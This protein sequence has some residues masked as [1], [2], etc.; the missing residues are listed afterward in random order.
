VRTLAALAVLA[1]AARVLLGP[2]TVGYDGQWA[3]LWGRDLAEGARPDMGGA[4]APTPHPLVNLVATALAPLGAAGEALLAATTYVAAA[5]LVLGCFA[6]GRALAGP[7]AGVLFAALVATRPLV[8]GAAMGVSVDVPWLALVLWAAALQARDAPRHRATAAL[9]VLAGLIR[10]ETWAVAAGWVV[11]LAVA[12]PGASLRVPLAAAVAAPVAWALSDLA[13]TGDALHSLTATQDLAARLERPTSAGTAAVALP[14]YLNAILGAPVAAGGALGLLVLL[15]RAPQRA[16]VPAALVFAGIGAF[17]ALGLAGL[18]LL[19]R[20][21]LLPAC[22]LALLFAVLVCG[23][24]AAARPVAVVAGALALLAAVQVPA[25]AAELRGWRAHA[26]ERRDVVRDLAAV[27]HAPE[28]RAARARCGRV[29][30]TAYRLAPVVALSLDLPVR[31]VGVT[32]HASRR[33][34][35]PSCPPTTRPWASPTTARTRRGRPCARRRASGPSPSGGAGRSSP[36]A[37]RAGA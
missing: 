32:G 9:L 21:A 19:Y 26:A 3:L 4:F 10:P 23:A 28:A 12:R 8:A 5:G 37:D 1:L 31:A 25:T 30:V 33:A 11:F 15:A 17:A 27:V 22:G 7:A 13:L 34:A 14:E 6:L 29:T 18:P 2:A 24:R 36:T 16:L 35:W 20:Y